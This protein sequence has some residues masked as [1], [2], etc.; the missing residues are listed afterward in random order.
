MLKDIIYILIGCPIT[1]FIGAIIYFYC[2]GREGSFINTWGYCFFLFFFSELGGYL[3]KR[4][5]YKNK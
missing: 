1:S 5:F 4:K 2:F 3:I